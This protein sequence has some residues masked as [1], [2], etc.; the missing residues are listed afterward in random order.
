MAPEQSPEQPTSEYA[1]ANSW[2]GDA[3]AV[4]MLTFAVDG[5][6]PVLAAGRRHADNAMAITH[7]QFDAR[8]GVPRLLSILDEFGIKATFF[9]P[10]L[11]AELWPGVVTAITEHGHDIAHHSYSH[12]P[13]TGLSAIEERIEFERGC[14]ALAALG[15]SASGYRSPMWAAT[16]NSAELAV[17]H[18]LTYDTSLMDDDRPYIIETDRGP[19]V[20]LP[21]H[22]SLDDWEQYA[23]LP[24]PH[25]G[26]VIEPPEKA[27][28][29]WTAELDG[30]RE[31]GG[32]F[33]LTAHSFLSGRAGRARNLRRMI[34]IICER[35]DVAFMTGT[36]LRDAVLADPT[37][38]RRKLDRLTVDPAVYPNW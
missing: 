35:G 22:W 8:R 15:I 33:Q 11:S 30:L 9:V 36:Q 12:R 21:P 7:Q 34:E 4:A 20:E 25:L 6:T 29:L 10:G 37:V 17:E 18:G 27:L 32:L 26:Y 1:G 13:A 16:W 28:S 14:E 31:F 5:V 19:L 24:E 3:A 2:R 23:Y 38:E